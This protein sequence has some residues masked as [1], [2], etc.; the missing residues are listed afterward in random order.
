MTGTARGTV[1]IADGTE[2]E[3]SSYG[4]GEPVVVIQT[5]LT[6]DELLPLTELLAQDPG[7]RA[8]HLGRRGYGT[9]SPA[10]V[11]ATMA[12]MAAACRDAIGALGVVPSHVVGG[13][14]SCVIALVLGA[15]A[16]SHV[17]SLTLVEPPP[18]AGPGAVEFRASTARLI[19]TATTR[20]TEAALDDFMPVL[21]GPTWREDS[22][23]AAPAALAALERDART[24]FAVDLPAVLSYRV[25]RDELAAVRCPVL[26]IG[27]EESAAWFREARELLKQ[28]LPHAEEA[29][30][31]RAGHLVAT[32]HPRELAELIVDFVRRQA[33]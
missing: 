12:D 14:F 19:A 32:T 30:V 10:N 15:L 2:L 7:L 8:I 17:L 24:F 26:L 9:S 25:D 28:W 33:W 4:A 16:P 1:A 27:G 3:V 20:G 29:T 23:F 22:E 21:Y 13:S 31:D 11:G 18:L 6:G 5:A